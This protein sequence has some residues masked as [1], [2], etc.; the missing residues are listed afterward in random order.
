MTLLRAVMLATM[1]LSGLGVAT[2]LNVPFQNFSKSC[3]SPRCWRLAVL[4]CDPRDGEGSLGPSWSENSGCIFVFMDSKTRSNLVL[5]PT[6]AQSWKHTHST[7]V[8]QELSKY[9]IKARRVQRLFCASSP[10][11]AAGQCVSASVGSSLLSG[12]VGRRTKADPLQL[13][14][15]YCSWEWERV[16]EIFFLRLSSSVTSAALWDGVWVRVGS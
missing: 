12:S 8:A 15:G 13:E 16:G 14:A 2:A 10:L 11:A 7:V 1:T 5:H 4:L 6:D 3:F 9:W